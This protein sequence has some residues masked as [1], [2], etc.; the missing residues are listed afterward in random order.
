MA[1]YT[2]P[3]QALI[4]DLIELVTGEANDMEHWPEILAFQLA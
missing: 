3:V 1:I 2:Q 4:D